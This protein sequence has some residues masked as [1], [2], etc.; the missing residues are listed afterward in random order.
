M[1]IL[2]KRPILGRLLPGVSHLCLDGRLHYQASPCFEC[3]ILMA[4]DEED[5][6]FEE[7]FDFVDEDDEDTN[8]TQSEQLEQAEDRPA[9]PKRRSTRSAKDE[10][11]ADDQEQGSQEEP[12]S[13]AEVAEEQQ[14]AEPVGPPADHVVHLYEYGEFKRTVQREFT[15]DDADAFAVEFNRTSEAHG[16]LAVPADKEAD[17]RP[18]V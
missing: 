4:Y 7:E 1:T 5:N 11:Q 14:P 18:T 9:K 2:P 6:L 10:T 17:P 8:E 3:E 15:S 16:R 12:E 13:N